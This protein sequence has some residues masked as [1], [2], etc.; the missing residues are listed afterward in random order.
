MSFFIMVVKKESA[1]EI[2]WGAR[3]ARSRPNG[4]NLDLITRP[5]ELHHLLT[6][7]TLVF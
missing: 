7:V 1:P 6:H 5:R 3:K 4:I 2:L